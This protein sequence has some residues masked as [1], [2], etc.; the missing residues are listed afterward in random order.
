MTP[1][2]VNENSCITEHD[3]PEDTSGPRLRRLGQNGL[4]QQKSIDA[5]FSDFFSILKMWIHFIYLEL[6]KEFRHLFAFFCHR[7]F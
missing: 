4:N 2:N 7:T 3:T 6:T 5:I 1:E